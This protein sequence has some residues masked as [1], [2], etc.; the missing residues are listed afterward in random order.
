M[1]VVRVLHY[2][3]QFFAGFGGEGEAGSPPCLEPRP[4]GPGRLL[5]HNLAGGGRI[6]GT[7]VCGDERFHREPAAC[8][9]AL[10]R[11]AATCDADV[12]VAG[13][14][15]DAGR[16]GIACGH[17][18][19]A[20][21]ARLG[22]PSVTAMFPDNPAVAL[23]RG[24][25]YILPTPA[26]AVGMGDAMA[27]LAAF[28]MRLAAGDP[29][30]AAEEEGY[31]PRGRRLNV[32]RPR[33]AAERVVN[34]L[35]LK[36]H[37]T[38]SAGEIQV[39]ADE[40][41]CPAPAVARLSAARIALITEGGIVPRG[42]PDRIESRRATSWRGYPLPDRLSPEG[43]ECVHAGFDTRWV[44]ADP[45]RVLPLDAARKIARAGVIGALHDRYYVTVGVGT[46]AEHARRFG[47]E[48]AAE[49]TRDGVAAAV[50]TAT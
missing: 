16:Y 43:Y 24:E 23:H 18:A 49:L 28:S 1:N 13:P 41:L 8:I 12:L 34:A 17:V 15:F 25:T 35:L 37:G 45:N 36:L 26:T 14:A 38:P 33:S 21:G 6:V 46:T 2:L 39:P 29:I 30:G 5:E 32:L 44:A 11:L 7:L 40:P 48:I 42:N 50:M 4:L 19:G 31:L 22:I 3:N 20:L 10:A 9:D 47:R 27:R